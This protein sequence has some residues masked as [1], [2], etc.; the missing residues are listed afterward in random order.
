MINPGFDE[1]DD[2]E[3]QAP[4]APH[5]DYFDPMPPEAQLPRG[6]WQDPHPAGDAH[7]NPLYYFVSVPGGGAVRIRVCEEHFALLGRLLG[8]GPH[9]CDAE[10]CGHREMAVTRAAEAVAGAVRDADSEG[11]PGALVVSLR[12]IARSITAGPFPVTGIASEREVRFNW[13]FTDADMPDVVNR[14]RVILGHPPVLGRASAATGERLLSPPAPGQRTYTA[15]L[16]TDPGMTGGPY[17]TVEVSANDDAGQPGQVVEHPWVLEV[18]T[19]DSDLPGKAPAAA[20]EQLR[21]AGWK[22]TGPWSFKGSAF[23]APAELALT[24]A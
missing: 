2:D 22:L 8:E 19:D 6:I 4:A 7:G 1:D 16:D 18:S 5:C 13:M 15:V 9:I 3:P 20:G 14:A 11:L 12:E 17:C 23:Y 24:E 21:R 10:Q